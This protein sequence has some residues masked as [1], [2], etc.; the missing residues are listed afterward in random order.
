MASSDADTHKRIK[1]THEDAEVIKEDTIAL[2]LYTND[3]VRFISPMRL[4]KDGTH[5]VIAFTHRGVSED[6]SLIHVWTLAPQKLQA[7]FDGHYGAVVKIMEISDDNRYVA[8][9]RALLGGCIKMWD[10]VQGQLAFQ[11]EGECSTMCFSPDSKELLIGTTLTGTTIIRDVKNGNVTRILDWEK[12]GVGHALCWF[13]DGERIIGASYAGCMEV[14]DLKKECNMGIKFTIINQHVKV[15]QLALCPTEEYC[16]VL[17]D[18]GRISINEIKTGNLLGAFKHMDCMR[19][20]FSADGAVL[21]TTSDYYTRFYH[22][23]PEK[24]NTDVVTKLKGIYLWSD[25]ATCNLNS[26]T[27]IG[28]CNTPDGLYVLHTD[29]DKKQLVLQKVRVDKRW[30]TEALFG[31]IKHAANTS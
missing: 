20:C 15:L 25:E 2:K 1:I 28:R 26:I 18:Y 21:M 29:V 27:D 14:W 19:V 30:D 12:F 6:P 16:V 22:F 4:S 11:W 5:L 17:Y 13:K 10:V 8:T 31:H 23:C 9:C 7:T 3:S 24:V